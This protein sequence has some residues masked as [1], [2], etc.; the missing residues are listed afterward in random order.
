MK[1]LTIPVIGVLMLIA[2]CLSAQ[3]KKADWQKEFAG[4]SWGSTLAEI[5][6][7]QP[8]AKCTT[9]LRTETA[10]SKDRGT[11]CTL[12]PTT[13]SLRLGRKVWVVAGQMSRAMVFFE[14]GDY[15]EIRQL[16]VEKYGPPTESGSYSEMWE[17]PTVVATLDGLRSLVPTVT[18]ATRVAVDNENKEAAAKNEKTKEKF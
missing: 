1:K 2:T 11:V 18:L 8:K 15:K 14:Q 9:S 10:Q 6:A 7:A 5:K 4:L 16:L 17:G 13:G 12:P 3:E